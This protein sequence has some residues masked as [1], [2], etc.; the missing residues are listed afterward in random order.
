MN[1]TL[2]RCCAALLLI[3]LGLF[4]HKPAEAAVSCSG[5]G[6]SVSDINF[7]SVNPL[8]GAVDVTGTLSGY[9]CTNTGNASS[10]GNS[11]QTFELCFDL[12]GQ[13]S[14]PRSMNDSNGDVLQFELYTDSAHSIVWGNQSYGTPLTTAPFTLPSDSLPHTGPPLTIY[15]RVFGGQTSAQPGNYSDF[16][17]AGQITFT[18]TNTNGSATPSSCQNAGTLVTTSASFT[19]KASVTA[20]CS[21]NA[22]TLDF[23]TPGLLTSA[24]PSTSSIGVQCASGVAYNVGL[25][26]GLHS[27]NS[28]NARKMVLG[29]NSVAYQLYRDSGRTAV[30]GNTV[31]TNTVSGTGT[32]SIQ[33]LTVYGQVPAQTT[34]PAGTYT[35]TVVVSVTY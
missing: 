3:G 28:I 30:W 5:S 32:G 31:N 26:G 2:L 8:S 18:F 29:A 20:L 12:L 33:N 15:G 34:P 11:P 1:H 6:M 13:N 25:D 23:G 22:V 16:F 35:D 9:T 10:N 27:G 14:S 21:V 24:V 4:W 17:S 7:G 19:A